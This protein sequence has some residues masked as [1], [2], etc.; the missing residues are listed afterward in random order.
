MVLGITGQNTA[1]A[2][3]GR[4][5]RCAGPARRWAVQ[6]LA[7]CKLL[8]L[9][10]QKAFLQLPFHR[11]Q[12]CI[13]A[14]RGR[15]SC[16]RLGSRTGWVTTFRCQCSVGSDPSSSPPVAVGMQL[17]GEG[18]VRARGPGTVAPHLSLVSCAP[19]PLSLLRTEAISHF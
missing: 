2:P 14:L 17:G 18:A 11:K 9:I 19:S 6:L 12:A 7:A 10:P 15:F 1:A 4:G 13:P 16:V 3:R 8:R 5:R